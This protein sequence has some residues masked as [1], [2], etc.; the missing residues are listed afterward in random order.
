[1]LAA[2]QHGPAHRCS[3]YKWCYDGMYILWHRWERHSDSLRCHTSPPAFATGRDALLR[4]AQVIY[5]RLPF[6]LQPRPTLLM[7]YHM[8][9]V[10]LWPRAR[11]SGPVRTYWRLLLG[12]RN[13]GVQRTQWLATPTRIGRS[14][15]V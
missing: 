7:S 12:G 14:A 3:K 11:L 4:C 15:V 6:H 1:M 8:S 10:T 5:T 2:T 13:M 9:Q